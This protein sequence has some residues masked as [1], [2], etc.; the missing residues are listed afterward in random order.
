[1][2]TRTR[3]H[4]QFAALILLFALTLGA[5]PAPALTQPRARRSDAA[6]QTTKPT[7]TP[8]LPVAPVIPAATQTPTPTPSPTQTRAT[9]P[10]TLEE[11]RARITQI[12]SKPEF[13][14]SRM[15]VKVASLDTGRVLFEQDAQE[16]M[17]PAS[18]MKLYTVAAALDRLTPDYRFITSV[19]APAKPDAAGTVRGDLVVY[20]RGDPSYAT[21]FNPEGNA[22]YYHAIGE[23]ASS[24]A[25]AGVRRVEGDLVGDE[26]YFKGS[27]LPAGW[28]WDDLQWW[29]GAEVR[30]LT[31][32]DNSVDLSV[33][34]G[35]RVGDPCRITVGPA[36]SVL[37]VVD[38]TATSARGTTREL[39][40]H[41]PLGGS[42]IE[43]R[44][45]MALDDRGLAAS[46][47]APR[48]ALMFATML[49]SAL[50]RRGVVF[51]GQTKTIDAQARADANQP[52]PISSLVEIAMR[53]SPPLSVIAAQT[54]KPSQNL[55]TEL[56]LRALGKATAIDPKKT[57]EEAGIE[58]IRSFLSKAGIDPGKV[59]ILDGSGL[60]RAD[61]I[62]ADATVQLLTYMNRHAYS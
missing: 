41:R 11:L 20:G 46:V 53:R 13:A 24:I 28:E 55:Y 33:K 59:S 9:P 48:P 57:S 4:S 8:S 6:Q 54:M 21:R 50:E 49:R 61:L 14:P 29:Y 39:A 56:I 44:G 17:Q 25:D 10:Q 52:L 51:T 47:A 22:D 42:T 5:M 26:S 18:N 62:T 27:S 1:M 43:I 7:P 32:N 15:S 37:T 58:A 2:P 38:R 19:Y 45:T 31:V 23:L 60:S 36:T 34:P 30:A 12:L 3:L 35:A 16:W 40:V